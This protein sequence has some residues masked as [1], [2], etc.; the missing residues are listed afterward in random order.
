MKKPHATAA[1]LSAAALLSPAAL[2]QTAE[3]QTQEAAVSRAH[4]DAQVKSLQQDFERRLAELEKRLAADEQEMRAQDAAIVKQVTD[5]TSSEQ[6]VKAALK[7]KW[8][9]RISL[10]G[11]TQFRYTTLF[12]D[13][14]TPNLVVPNDPTVSESETFYIRRGRFVFSGDASE[15]VYLYAQVDYFGS[16][17]GSG[18]KGVQTRDLY[19]DIALDADK[20]YRFR[21]GQSKVPYGFVNLQ[22][23]QNRAPMERPDAL[24]SG[25]EGERDYGVFFMW[26]PKEVRERF[27]Q[28]VKDGLKG[29]GDYG[30]ISAGAYSGQGLNRSDLN[31]EVHWIA[32]ASYPY[33]FD[34]GQILELGIGGYTGDFV[35][36]TQA[37]GGVT[38]TAKADGL[39]DERVAIGAVLYPQPF[40]FEAE[41]TWGRGPQLQSNQTSI[42]VES[43]QG[44]YLQAN[45]MLE[46]SRGNVFPFARWNYFDGGRKFARN[47][48]WDEVSELD[49][50]FEWSPWPELELALMYT[51]TFHRTNTTSAPFDETEDVDR[52]GFQVQWNY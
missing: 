6:A 49:L 51:H 30:V 21:L 29:S 20:E 9:E 4:F 31:G 36:G 38:P 43:L 35:V 37:I 50:G 47:A 52:I 1:A 25:V 48:P 8:Y 32:R 41:W 18:D 28:L 16:V 33:E 24:N 26:A 12:N 19:A 23:S 11:Y 5:N 44:G 27:K 3:A 2:G 42:E 40:G 34:N 46:T 13:D 7:G 22:S 17:G 14:V 10:R 15:H 39:D 45:Y